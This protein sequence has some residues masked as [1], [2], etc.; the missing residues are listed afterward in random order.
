VDAVNVDELIAKARAELET[1]EP[2]DLDVLLGK[3]LVKVRLWPLTGGEWRALTA[4]HPPRERSVF[5]QNL[6]YNLDSVVRDY[7][8]VF[9]VDGDEVVNVA[10]EDDP[11][12]PGHRKWH[13]VYDV[14]DGPDMKNLASA[15][16]GLNEFEHQKRVAAAGKASAGARRKKRD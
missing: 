1:V 5:D 11:E 13:D 16:W 14:L 10:V 8:K 4:V 6:G 9:L 7:P 2:V 3:T 15:V 12:N